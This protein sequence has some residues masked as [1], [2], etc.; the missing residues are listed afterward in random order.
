MKMRL[1]RYI[2]TALLSLRETIVGEGHNPPVRATLPSTYV[3][4]GARDVPDTRIIIPFCAKI[5]NLSVG[6][7]TG[8]PQTDGR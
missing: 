2:G 1:R 7:T 5:I 4:Y 8:H 3:G 6:T